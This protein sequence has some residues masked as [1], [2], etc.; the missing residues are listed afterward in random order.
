VINATPLDNRESPLE[1]FSGHGLA[2]DMNY[3]GTPF[4]E[5]ARAA[6]WDT[7]DGRGMFIDQA[8]AQFILWTGFPLPD[9]AVSAVDLTLSPPAPPTSN[10]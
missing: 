5:T 1:N 6:G 9:A 10:P 2:Y 4:L 8:S 3:R 7:L